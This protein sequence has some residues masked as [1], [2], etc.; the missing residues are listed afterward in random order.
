M[1]KTLLI[2]LL[3]LAGFTAPAQDIILG[4][5][6]SFYSSWLFNK[7]VS[8]QDASLDYASTFSTTFGAQALFMF[9]ET[10]GVN[11]ELIV[12]SQKQKYDGY[13][14][15]DDNV[16]TNEIKLNYIDIPVLFRVSSPKGPYFEL[17]PQMS[18]LTGAKETFSFEQTDNL[19]YTDKN[20]KDDFAGFGVSGII[21]FGVD[22]KLSDNINL[23]TGLRF[24]YMFTDATVEYTKEEA[25]SLT[26]DDKLSNVAAYSHT[27]QKG[28]FDYSRSNRAFGGVQIGLQYVLGR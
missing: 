15:T 28:G 11:T 18:L 21:G 25:T 7:N 5:K 2:T 26:L 8:D 4:L 13:S 22:I 14:I 17:G 6:G 19:D 24:G 1:K 23:T 10:Y 9:S 27:T 16:F 12:A 3:A 20:V